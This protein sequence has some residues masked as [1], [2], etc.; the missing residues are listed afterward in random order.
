MS[1]LEFEPEMINGLS[2][3]ITGGS[4]NVVAQE[5]KPFMRMLRGLR[6]NCL[7]YC[8]SKRSNCG[9][10]TQTLLDKIVTQNRSRRALECLVINELRWRNASALMQSTCFGWQS[11]NFG[12]RKAFQLFGKIN[13]PVI[14]RI[15]Q[16]SNYTFYG[17]RASVETFC[18]VT[19]LV[20]RI[21]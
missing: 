8:V 20:L 4:P 1:P 17:L 11:V 13:K 14:I 3:P 16:K 19:I 15:H 18:S 6:A 9:P 21:Y 7:I 2:K 10:A 5:R 12:V